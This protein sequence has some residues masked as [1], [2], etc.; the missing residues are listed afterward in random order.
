L[1]LVFALFC[2][3]CSSP[4]ESQ[5]CREKVVTTAESQLYVRELTGRNDGL[6]VKKYLEVTGLGEG[7]PWCAAFVSWVF[8]EAGV[9]APHSARVVDWFKTNIVYEREWKKTTVLPEKGMVIGLYYSNLG[10]YGH[11]GIVAEKSPGQLRNVVTIEGNTNA[12][13]SREGQGVYRK[14]RPWKTIAV[15]A[16]YL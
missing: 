1:A 9:T 15:M 16:D 2:I 10:R 7:Y 4:V 13:G 5:D 6:E 8:V 11:I 3:A 14:I 12:A